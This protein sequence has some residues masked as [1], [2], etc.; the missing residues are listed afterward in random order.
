M[1]GPFTQWPF[2]PTGVLTETS[3]RSL[4]WYQVP[5][6]RE[7]ESVVHKMKEF[8]HLFQGRGQ[9]SVVLNG[10]AIGNSAF[11]C[12]TCGDDLC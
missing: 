2:G 10:Q 6:P 8:L 4:G 12:D 5:T 9:K 3:R 7:R 11:P 1:G